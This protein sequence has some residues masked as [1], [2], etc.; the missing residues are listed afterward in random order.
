MAD[1]SRG[2][3]SQMH[4]NANPFE[5][6]ETKRTAGQVSWLLAFAS[7]TFRKQQPALN[8]RINAHNFISIQ[9]FQLTPTP[10]AEAAAAGTAL[11][12]FLA[13]EKVANVARYNNFSNA[14]VC[15]RVCVCG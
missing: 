5:W 4:S 6:K 15:V 13:Y 1:A 10:A 12:K 9:V 2:R 8:L 7:P 11:S 14:C 3:G